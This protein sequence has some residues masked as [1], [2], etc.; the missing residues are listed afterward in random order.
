M[1]DTEEPSDRSLLEQNG[2]RPT[3][4]R[5]SQE[6]K[7]ISQWTKKQELTSDPKS[8]RGR[9][10]DRIYEGRPATLRVDVD[11]LNQQETLRGM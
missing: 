11:I 5:R 3:A 6:K 7:S 10:K 8:Q 1:Q 9:E 4:A 2:S